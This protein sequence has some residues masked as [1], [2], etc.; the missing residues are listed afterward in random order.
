MLKVWNNPP[1]KA[2]LFNAEAREEANTQGTKEGKSAELFCESGFVAA[3]EL[4]PG[5]AKD[6]SP[7]SPHNLSYKMR[8]HLFGRRHRI[9]YLSDDRGL[10]CSNI[11]NL[12][13]KLHPLPLSLTQWPDVTSVILGHHTS[14][15]LVTLDM[16]H[17]HHPEI[18]LLPQSNLT[19]DT[20]DWCTPKMAPTRSSHQPSNPAAQL[21]SAPST[22][23]ATT[24][25]TGM[26]VDRSTSIAAS[27]SLSASANQAS[28][29]SPSLDPT[30]AGQ[31]S[32]SVPSAASTT[33]ASPSRRSPPT[34]SLPSTQTDHLPQQQTQTHH[35]SEAR[36]AVVASISNL[37]DSELQ[38]RAKTLHSNAAA[39]TRQERDVTRATAALR[40][41]NDKLARWSSDAA[42]RVKELGNVQNWAEVLERE[43]LVLEETMRLVR[44]GS[45]ERGTVVAL[46]ARVGG[47]VVVM[48]RLWIGRLWKEMDQQRVGEDLVDDSR[49]MIPYQNST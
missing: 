38:T 17:L 34:T 1:G 40:A 44:E 49:H 11:V 45:E 29:S 3:K 16:D 6:E 7:T 33:T 21:L 32:H 13:S 36:A 20:Q 9:C 42:Q 4:I 2:A 43:F 39:I 22:T 10:H 47:L 25:A 30:R 12:L 23:T 5:C 41:E 14:L 28:I 46:A 19:F 31:A 18:C 26:S 15:P 35:V 37:L 8:T 27:P 48:L 24:L